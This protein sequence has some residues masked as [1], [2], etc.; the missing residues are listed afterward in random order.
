MEYIDGQTLSE[1]LGERERD[2]QAIVAR[3]VDAGEGL[4]AAHR[5][6][7]IHRD[8]KPKSRLTS[9]ERP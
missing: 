1:W 6:G 3:F 2:W 8:F 4:A 5:A 7:I 9:P